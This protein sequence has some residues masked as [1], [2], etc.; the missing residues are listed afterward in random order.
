[1]GSSML[2]SLRSRIASEMIFDTEPMRYWEFLL[3]AFVPLTLP[4]ARW[5]YS[6][7]G[8]FDA[9]WSSETTLTDMETLLVSHPG[10]IFPLVASSSV[11]VNF[12]SAAWKDFDLATCSGLGTIG[13]SG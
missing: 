11:P 4:E 3:I 8:T 9:S 7:S 10:L 12:L 13:P 5:W 1:M 6:Q 2:R